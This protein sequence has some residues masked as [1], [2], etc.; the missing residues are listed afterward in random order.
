[1]AIMRGFDMLGTLTRS[2]TGEPHPFSEERS[3][4]LFSEGAVCTLMLEDLEHA[5]ARGAEIYAEITDYVQH[6]A[7]NSCDIIWGNC[8]DDSL[9]DQICL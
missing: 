8:T 5:Q 1:M 9:K 6:A 7:G 2:D 4:F 3:G